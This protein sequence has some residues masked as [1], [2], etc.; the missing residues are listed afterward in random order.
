MK[1]YKKYKNNC[2]DVGTKSHSFQ[3]KLNIKKINKITNNKGNITFNNEI[4]KNPKVRLNNDTI[5][6]CSNGENITYNLL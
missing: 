5:S 6:N 2:H 3:V 4:S 1:L